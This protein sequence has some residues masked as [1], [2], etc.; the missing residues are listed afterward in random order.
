MKD[1]KTEK[2]VKAGYSKCELK[3]TVKTVK[4]TFT[5]G[6]TTILL[7]QRGYEEQKWK[8][9]KVAECKC[10]S[11]VDI[12]F[13][14]DMIS[15][16]KIPGFCLLYTNQFHGVKRSIMKYHFICVHLKNAIICN[17]QKHL[18]C[19]CKFVPVRGS[20]STNQNAHYHCMIC[21]KPC[22]KESAYKIHLQSKHAICD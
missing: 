20:D 15:E 22:D 10:F 21:H 17:K 7:K 5:K 14:G 8:E 11:H 1:P 2:S 4:K 12:T 19:K 13:D 18:L 3:S 16:Q 6:K 9:R